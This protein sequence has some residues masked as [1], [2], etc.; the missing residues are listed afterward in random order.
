MW[1]IQTTYRLKKIHLKPNIALRESSEVPTTSFAS[2][3]V[4]GPESLPPLPISDK[5]NRCQY[6]PC[7][8]VLGKVTITHDDNDNNDN[9]VCKRWRSSRCFVWPPAHAVPIQRKRQLS[10]FRIPQSNSFARLWHVWLPTNLDKKAFTFANWIS[11]HQPLLKLTHLA[12]QSGVVHSLV[13]RLWN[14]FSEI[15]FLA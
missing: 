2:T 11:I 12:A 9:P 14:A 15:C 8:C 13:Q 7:L 5:P 10:Y 4:I 1:K 6:F 3:S